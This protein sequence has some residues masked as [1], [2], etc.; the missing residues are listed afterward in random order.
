MRVWKS[1]LQPS[2]Y[3]SADG[4]MV[5]LLHHST[6]RDLCPQV[7]T[8][9]KKK[10]WFLRTPTLPFEGGGAMEPYFTTDSE[11]SLQ[12]CSIVFWMQD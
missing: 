10:F 9:H 3:G 4:Q 8:L 1:A 5:E 2:L 6:L 7:D 12:C 11:A